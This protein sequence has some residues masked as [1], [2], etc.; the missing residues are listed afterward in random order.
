[1]AR[2]A[3]PPPA[4]AGVR[5]MRRGRADL[6]AFLMLLGASVVVGSATGGGEL[7]LAGFLLWLPGLLLSCHRVRPFPGAAAR[8]RRFFTAER[9][10]FF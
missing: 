9:R 6:P 1:M 3:P 10:R 7:V 8:L 5:I 2:R 4:P